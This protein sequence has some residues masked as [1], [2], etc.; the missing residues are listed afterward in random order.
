MPTRTVRALPA[1]FALLAL[2]TLPQAA[3]AEYYAVNPTLGAV[4][5]A[6]T[7]DGTNHGEWS[8]ANLI[9]RDLA[10]DDPRSL[11]DSWTMHET[12]YDLTHLYAAWDDT[13]LYL[14]YQYVDVTDVIDPSNAGAAGGG[15]PGV[16]DLIQWI[17]IDTREG[18][19]AT[20]DMWGKNGGE[21]YWTGVD[22]PDFQIYVAGNLWQGFISEAVAGVFPV[23][24]GGVHYHTIADAGIEIAVGRGLASSTLW[25]V[26]DADRAS[27]P[28]AVIDFLTRAHS[29][30]RDTFYELSIPLATLGLTRADLEARGLGVMI[31][32][33]EMSCVDTIPNDP[34]TSDVTGVSPSNS[35]LE[36]G[37]IDPLTA[38]F[39]RVG[40]A[41]SGT[42]DPC[43]TV[44][45]DPD[46]RCVQGS[47]VADVEPDAGVDA[48]D[49]AS[50]DAD[51]P[52]ASEDV[53]EDAAD[54]PDASPDV[55]GEDAA[56]AVE[57]T[58][59]PTAP[60]SADVITV[61]APAGGWLH[62]GVNG[63]TQPGALDWPESTRVATAGQSVETALEGPDASG[64]WSVQLGPFSRGDIQSIEFVLHYADETWDNNGGQ[65]FHI[66]VTAAN[67]GANNGTNNATNNGANNGGGGWTGTKDSDAGDEGCGCAVPSGPARSRPGWLA[68]VGALAALA[69]R[70]R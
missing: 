14:A 20:L 44:T 46:E 62:W 52:D 37:D 47:C 2:L 6:I 61:Y 18:A 51:S 12:P 11:A 38:D 67:N 32:Q 65:D 17:V 54:L 8:E 7:I 15:S 4:A 45:C 9:A 30:A 41:R 34:A 26:E 59:S 70:R 31:G 23:D 53:A 3:R 29:V 16:L 68:L 35:P 21:P 43:A 33:G 13:H 57:V 10:N 5:G 58:W 42:P 22:R 50:P 63:W 48:A 24:D 19:G 55:L 60:T 39:A 36:W 64:R 27:D 69:W 49:D 40:A 1:L 28:T 66:A 25:G 56:P